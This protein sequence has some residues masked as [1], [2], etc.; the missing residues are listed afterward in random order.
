M[1]RK[2]RDE[3]IRPLTKE[4]EAGCYYRTYRKNNDDE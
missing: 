1:P 3:T 4:G 2:R